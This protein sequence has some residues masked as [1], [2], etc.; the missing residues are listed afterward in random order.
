MIRCAPGAQT[1]VALQETFKGRDSRLDA[2]LFPLLA[3]LFAGSGCAALI[4]EIVW[5]QLLEFLIGSTTV[6]LGVLLATFMGGLCIGSI[7]L[8]RI[9]ALRR[10]HP[11]RVFAAI[12]L[13]IGLCGLLVWWGM[14]FADRFY[15]AF[16]EYGLPPILLRAMVASLCL[17]PPT[18]LMGA[19]L[20]AA[21]RWIESSRR[22]IS[23]M[24]LLYGANTVGAVFGSLLAGFYLLRAFDMAATTYTAA[25]INALVAL[26]GF[27]V[28]RR[29]PVRTG[30][31]GSASPV[32]ATTKTQGESPSAWTVYA[33][34]AFSGATALG[35]E[36]VWMRL[37]GLTMG[38]TVYTFSIILAVFL[39]GLGVGGGAGA[40]LSRLVPPRMA[41][42]FSQ[43]LLTAAVAWT[44]YMLADSLPY[45]PAPPSSGPWLVFRT[46]LLRAS[47]AMLPGALLWGASFP[48]AL[49]AAARR[50]SE[51]ARLVGGVYAANT[52]GA[53]AGALIF[54]IVLIPR[55]GTLHS[56]RALILLSGVS[57]LFVFLGPLWPR[58]AGYAVLC[59]TATLGVTAAMA[60]N[61]PSLPPDL[62]AYGRRFLTTKDYAKVLFSAEGV[63]ST[64]A[65]S[66]WDGVTQFHVSGKVEASTGIY[67]MRLQRTLGHLPALL[68]PDPR[69]VLVV[70]FG[71]GVTSGSFTLH[72]DVRRIVICEIEPLIPP[73]ATRYFGNENY[74]VLHDPRTQMVYDDARHFVLTTPEKF[75]IITSDPIHPWVKGSATLYT[76]EY[77]QMVKDHLNPGGLVTQWVPLYETD[78]DT[79]KSELATFFEVFPDGSI[80]ANEDWQSGGYDVFLLGSKDPITIDVDALQRRM[81]SPEY[82]RVVQSLNDVAIATASDFLSIYTTQA[83]DLKPW[84]NGAVINRDRNLR[85]QFL[86]G[87]AVNNYLQGP[88]YDEMLA[89][90]RF[91]DNLIVGSDAGLQGLKLSLRPP[92]EQDIDP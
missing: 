65:V 55:I 83:S 6:S 10:Y 75:D 78:L 88:I 52:G 59:L 2:R 13:G 69:S 49:A 85:L 81:D 7:A 5:Y 8:P 82:A 9:A 70:G 86:A 91:P 48:L 61:L 18:I 51:S 80:W 19:S 68:H 35:A 17:L 1:I 45:W 21:A 31:D 92:Q 29:A 64:I 22:G 72:P 3:V 40:W 25:A 24:G 76:R 89:Y 53:I 42:G 63:N 39:V 43:L 44:A 74:N 27:L 38:A 12:E 32:Q 47:A 67:D 90:R 60:G 23:W 66:D 28:S 11:L 56:Q 30:A 54:S 14:P 73:V 33:T 46:D 79:V 16:L 37:L 62:I 36:T 50:G 87:M 57:A 77:F 41:L 71:A 84:L 58:R 26:A 4:Y 15:L 34:I 20:P